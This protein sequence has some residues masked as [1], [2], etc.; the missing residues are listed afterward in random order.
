MMIQVIGFIAEEES[1]TKSARVKNA[2]RKSKNGNT[3]S[4]KGNRWGRKPISTQTTQKVIELRKEGK[5]IRDISSIVKI[6]DSNNNGRNIS[7]STVHK[8]LA[9]FEATKDSF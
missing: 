5:S 4:Y 3:I 8:I 7:K 6:Y 1:S 2:V 9:E